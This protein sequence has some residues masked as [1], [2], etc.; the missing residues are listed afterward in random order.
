MF[1][2]ATA[3]PG[4]ADLETELVNVRR[5]IDAGA[6]FL[7]TQAIYDPATLGRFLEAL[8]P[9][10][11]AVLAGIIPLKSAKMA[12]WLNTNVPGIRVPEGLIA[13]MALAADA[14]AQTRAGIGIAARTIR[15]VRNLCAGVHVMALGWDS[16]VPG[17]LESAGLV[18]PVAVPE[19]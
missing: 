13:E 16:H 10:E 11:V 6:Q 18:V 15:A 9:R 5:K 3:N 19:V 14:A 7:Q 1:L 8:K 12:T 4:A 17:I 2:G